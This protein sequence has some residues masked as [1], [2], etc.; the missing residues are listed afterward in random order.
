MKE[1]MKDE[2]G[3]GGEFRLGEFQ[4]RLERYSRSSLKEDE[5]DEEP[6]F[7]TPEK[8]FARARTSQDT[9]ENLK[10]I[11]DNISSKVNEL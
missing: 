7:R 1:K 3:R 5:Q 9:A 10:R 2:K 4:M 6:G 11:V 8:M